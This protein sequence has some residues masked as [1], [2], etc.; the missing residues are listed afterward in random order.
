MIEQLIKTILSYP[1]ARTEGQDH[2]LCDDITNIP[3][4]AIPKFNL[5]LS[6]LLKANQRFSKTVTPVTRY[7]W[8]QKLDNF[9]LSLPEPPTDFIVANRERRLQLGILNP[10]I[11]K[12]LS[13]EYY[14]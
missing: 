13:T 11:F 1:A 7:H 4:E 2:L 9:L 8:L 3:R 6:S 14:D 12:S 5:E 10:D